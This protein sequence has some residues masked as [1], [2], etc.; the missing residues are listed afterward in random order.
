MEKPKLSMSHEKSCML[1]LKG[2]IWL[3]DKHPGECKMAFRT[4]A[5]DFVKVLFEDNVKFVR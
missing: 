5:V 2:M 1:F 4:Y 3:I